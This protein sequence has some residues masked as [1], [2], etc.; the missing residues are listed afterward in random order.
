HDSLR[1]K[2]LVVA[3]RVPWPPLDGGRVAINAIAL[4]LRDAGAEVEMIALDPRK[5]R[6]NARAIP[7]RR[8][9]LPLTA[10][11]HDTSVSSVRVAAGLAGRK[12]VIASRFRSAEL[13]RRVR[14]RVARG[15]V[16]V[17]QIEGPMLSG[18]IDAARAG[19]PRT[20]VAMRS[21][22]VEHLIWETLARGARWPWARLAMRRVASQLRAHEHAANGQSDAVVA[23]S[24]ADLDEFRRM[25]CGK[26]GI[27]IPVG[28]D[29]GAC[30]FAPRE[31]RGVFL[32]GSLDYR[33]NVEALL[34][35]AAEVMPR[36]TRLA[37][38]TAVIAAG[39]N[40]PEG[41]A[42]RI[43][44]AG[45]RFVGQVPDARDFM[46]TGGVM[47]VP[48]LS[49]SGMR[50]KIAEAMALGVPVVSTTRGAD[51]L[52]V[53]HDRELAIADGADDFAE[54]LVRVEG[55]LSLRARL[56]GTARALVERE[57]DRETLGGVLLDF[58]AELR[59]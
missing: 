7:D 17:V 6:S 35:F 39:S 57:L 41:L 44:A 40:A 21:Q 53:V 10:V 54:A 26:A 31:A 56:A 11:P 22:N 2:V 36:L 51:G 42:A 4:G 3:P 30:G 34:W 5:H 43:E 29:T 24:R 47:A 1:M 33:P 45:I 18:C 32:L 8:G 19:D 37:P 9:E 14:E 16:D 46:T 38:A 28:I 15:D 20:L 13:E 59:G 12:S 58:Y 27:V 25:G 50:V 52:G 49:G 48:L 55:D 23:I